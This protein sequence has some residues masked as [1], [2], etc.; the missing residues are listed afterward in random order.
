MVTVKCGVEMGEL[1]YINHACEV[2]L[3]EKM[4]NKQ[5]IVASVMVISIGNGKLIGRFKIIVQN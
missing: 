3:M 2:L 4:S 5:L 1:F